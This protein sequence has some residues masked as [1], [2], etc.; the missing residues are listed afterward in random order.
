MYL[1]I[2]KVTINFVY[3]KL[4]ALIRENLPL[5]QIV[6]LI[7][8]FLGY[9]VVDGMIMCKRCGKKYKYKKNFQRHV[10]YECHKPPQFSCYFCPSRFTQNSSL[11]THMATHHHVY[12]IKI[13]KLYRCPKCGKGYKH[14]PNLYRHA[15][16]ECDGI[17]HFV[18][19]I[20]SKA[21]TQ[22]VNTNAKLAESPTGISR[23]CTDIKNT[24]VRVSPISDA[25]TV[26][27]LFKCGTSLAR[28]AWLHNFF[29]G[30]QC[31]KCG[32]VYK[33]RCNLYRHSKYHCDGISHFVC[34]VC[35]KAYTQKS[36][37][38]HH[39][40]T[41]HPDQ[42][43]LV[44]SRSDQK[45]QILIEFV[46][47]AGS[48]NMEDFSIPENELFTCLCNNCG[49][50]KFIRVQTVTDRTDQATLFGDTLS[51]CVAVKDHHLQGTDSST[52]ITSVIDAKNHTNA[53]AQSDAI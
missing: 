36:S 42:K 7:L 19:A 11:K 39:V 23:T 30:F 20:C 38:Q 18:C 47:G 16:Y 6:G 17:S 31:K 24:N 41:I 5:N 28:L 35:S 53:K 14:K 46:T 4:L 50:G 51:T 44:Q 49:K 9:V 1:L 37:L 40:W 52:T 3:V 34:P 32:K 48:E 22:K 29:L 26:L 10:K 15:K 25:S 21:Y 45:E 27:R 43:P 8:F 13:H 12:D 33:H 2:V